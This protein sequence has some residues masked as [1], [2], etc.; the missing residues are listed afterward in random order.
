MADR[1]DA[2]IRW[3]QLISRLKTWKSGG[4]RA[5]HKPLL[6]LML[7]ARAQRGASSSVEYAEI[8]QPLHE[9]LF[10]F[11]PPRKSIHPEYPFWHLQSD[12]FWVIPAAPVLEPRKKSRQIP[13]S[14]L[15]RKHVHG[16]VPP[17]LW[18]ALLDH[19]DLVVLLARALLDEFWEESQHDDICTAI[20]LDLSPYREWTSRRPRDPAFRDDVLRA[21]SRRCS[22]CGY[23]GRLGNTPF[24]LEAA[25][26]HS[27][28]FGGPDVIQNGLALCSLHHKAFDFGAISIDRGLRVLV[29]DDVCGGEAVGDTLLRFANRP[30]V[31]LVR[32]DYR[33]SERF[34]DWH[35]KNVFHSPAR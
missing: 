28:C 27:H 3:K 20:G 30:L 25:H 6:T 31:G 16:E 18:S 13:K 34:I 15:L 8:D 21:W 32:D 23:D 17:D 11:G 22:V 33:P 12:E 35:A 4:Q 19:P 2:E 10:Q 7:L 14:E 9:L 29:S 5:V 24:G 26:I 1:F